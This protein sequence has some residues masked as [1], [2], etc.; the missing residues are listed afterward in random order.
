MHASN[1]SKVHFYMSDANQNDYITLS[2]VTVALV[3]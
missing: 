2:E 1:I 3:K